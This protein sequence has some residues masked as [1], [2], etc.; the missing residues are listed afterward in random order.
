MKVIAFGHRREVGKDTA[1]GFLISHLRTSKSG[2]NVRKMGFADQLK[3]ISFRLYS[4]AGLHDGDYYETNRVA[5]EQVLPAIGKSPRDIWIEVGN[6]LRDVWADT[7]LDLL[8][9]GTK[10]D[11]MIIKDLRYL[12]EAEAVKA[13]GGLVIRIDNPRV[14]V[15]NDV[16]DVALVNY[17]KWDHVIT[18]D[19]DM[20]KFHGQ[21]IAM[22]NQFGF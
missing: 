3:D 17:D 11:F 14:K 6:K 15:F 13:A 22:A 12:N 7:W 5:K 10:C 19:D 16:A 4:W 20:K 18:N 9:K 8:F 2:R 1:A 21:V